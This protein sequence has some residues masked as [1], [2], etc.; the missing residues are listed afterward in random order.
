MDI[1]GRT[2][3]E[4]GNVVFDADGLID[5]LMRGNELSGELVTQQSEGV[6]RFNALCKELDH[7]QDTVAIYSRPEVD[8]ATWDQNLQNQWFTPEP[9]ASLDV[10]TWLTEKCSETKQLERVIE[11][12]VLFEEREMIPVLRCL[13]H[14]VESF[15]ER[16]VVWGVGRG[17]SVASYCLFL[18]GIHK[19]DSIKYE[20]DI[21]EFLK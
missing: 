20:L 11:E 19:V 7:P 4:W 5:L 3:D 12:W 21:R 17:S 13:I 8:V 9:Y 10:L 2:I 18:I 1:K 16:K 6:S 14:M 15:R